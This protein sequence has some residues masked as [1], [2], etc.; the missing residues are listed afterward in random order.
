MKR[1][2]S[3]LIFSILIV[4]FFVGF[5]VVSR[6]GEIEP[7]E[8]TIQNPLDGTFT[9]DS[10]KTQKE[11]TSEWEDFL[12]WY[13]PRVL[14]AS[15]EV[16]ALIKK[17]DP[18]HKRT[19]GDR[20]L[21]LEQMYPTDEWLQMLLDMGITIDDFSDYSY[22]LSTRWRFI[23]AQNDPEFL[24]ILQ[25]RNG[26][27]ENASWEE[28]MKTQLLRNVKLHELSEQAQEEDPLVYGGSLSEDGV[29]IP[30]RFK[31]VYVQPSDNFIRGGSGVPRWVIYEIRKREQG[32]EAKEIPEDIEVIY[33]DTDGKP[34][35]EDA[36]KPQTGFSQ[37]VLEPSAPSRSEADSV[38]ESVPG[39]QTLPDDFDNGSPTS[40]EET[41]DP[42]ERSKP[43]E[44]NTAR[45]PKSESDWEKLLAPEVPDLEKSLSEERV[46]WVTETLNRYGVEE[47]IRRIEAKDPSVA[48]RIRRNLSK[49]SGRGSTSSANNPSSENR[50]ERPR[51]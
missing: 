42:P 35:P 14:R 43:F 4:C 25:E 46:R 24:R 16:Q 36:P 41:L 8:N 26:L 38:F 33:L 40:R 2:I 15:P 32:L 12:S 50:K 51:R 29:F 10:T 9:R 49:T 37:S 27:D 45:L 11:T 23:H 20:N 47:G 17:F 48:E 3:I 34:L 31:T 21:E 5:A 30:T 22:Y 19:R 7:S 28:L 6:R 1:Y 39:G 44:F 13:K 18:S